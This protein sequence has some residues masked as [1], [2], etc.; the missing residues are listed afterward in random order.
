MNCELVRR[1]RADQAVRAGT[2]C[3]TDQDADR[4]DMRELL[5]QDSGECLLSEG[6]L[7]D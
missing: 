6:D 3:L 2:A 5:E 1:T 4:G 7:D